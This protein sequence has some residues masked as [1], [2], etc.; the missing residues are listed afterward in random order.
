[1]TDVAIPGP[2]CAS[3]GTA[4]QEWIVAVALLAFVEV[5]INRSNS[6][7]SANPAHAYPGDAVTTVVAHRDATR[8]VGFDLDHLDAPI[9]IAID[10]VV[11]AMT[12]GVA[13]A[14][15]G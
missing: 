11:V 6:S 7:P 14:R 5:Q 1:M 15:H 13:L 12:S 9:S 2:V 3:N 8:R 10:Q 4:T